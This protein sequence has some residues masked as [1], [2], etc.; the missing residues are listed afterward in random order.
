MH[1][2]EK[3]WIPVI[4]T[5]CS[6]QRFRGYPKS[7]EA[8]NCRSGRRGTGTQIGKTENDVEYQ[9]RKFISIL[10]EN[11]KQNAQKRKICKP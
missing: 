6:I 7:E 9:I 4:R 1:K 8:R 2:R 11:R 10:E 5:R 3:F